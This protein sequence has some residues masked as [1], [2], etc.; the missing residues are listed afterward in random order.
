MENYFIFCF[1]PIIGVKENNLYEDLNLPPNLAV[2][3]I[4]GLFLYY[5]TMKGK[6]P[7][8]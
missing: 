8:N 3:W 2:N 1:N 6:Y 5:L 4:I 7:F